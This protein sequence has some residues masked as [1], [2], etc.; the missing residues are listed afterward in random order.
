LTGVKDARPTVGHHVAMSRSDRRLRRE[1][2]TVH[3]MLELYCRAHHGGGATPC[4]A[5]AEL[6]AYADR[7]LDRCPY[8]VDK[9]TC[10]NCPIHCYRPLPRERMREVMRWAGPRMLRRHPVLALFHLLD[11]R[12]EPPPQPPARRGSA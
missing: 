4:S 8:G 9:P 1:R 3:A 7:R 12:R 11:G 5:C 6:G 2:R 10:V